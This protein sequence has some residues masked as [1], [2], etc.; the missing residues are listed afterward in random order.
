MGMLRMEVNSVSPVAGNP[1]QHWRGKRL[2]R[3]R[4]DKRVYQ[5]T[6]EK[7]EGVWR[8]D[9]VAESGDEEGERPGLDQRLFDRLRPVGVVSMGM[10]WVWFLSDMV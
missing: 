1:T 4:K 7:D 2:E 9:M 8:A 10:G 5:N 6:Y 3:W